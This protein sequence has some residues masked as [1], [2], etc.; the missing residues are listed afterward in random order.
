MN[1]IK[2][3]YFVGRGVL[4]VVEDHDDDTCRAVYTVKFGAAIYVLHA[5]QKKS[6]S[7]IAMPRSELDLI[8][9]RLR[10]AEIRHRNFSA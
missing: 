4:E 8:S 9:A 3:C 1:G 6:K 2:P 10:S 5:F 7:G